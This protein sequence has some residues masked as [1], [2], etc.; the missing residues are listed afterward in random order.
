MCNLLVPLL[1]ELARTVTRV[2]VPQN[3]RPHLT[4]SYEIPPTWK[5]RPS[6]LHAPGTGW[7]SYTPG[8]WVTNHSEAEAKLRPTVNRPVCLSVG[9]P[10]GKTKE[11]Q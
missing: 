8:N 2:P 11:S 5:A 7:P 4:V 1:L 9:L 6:Y 10:S 3:S